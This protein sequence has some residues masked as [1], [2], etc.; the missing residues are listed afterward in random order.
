VPSPPPSISISR[1]AARFALPLASWWAIAAFARR[2][3]IASGAAEGAYL[4]LLAAAVLL[5]VSEIAPWPA[6]ELGI[7][8]LLAAAVVWALP[9]GPAR[10]TVFLVVLTAAFL[11]AACRRL[12]GA[13]AREGLPFGAYAALALGSQF[14][15]R[16]HLLFAPERTLKT[17]V[18]LLVLPL[19]GAA[20]VA[21]TARREGLGPT[22]TAAALSLLLAPGWNVSSTL[23]WVALAATVSLARRE[24]DGKERLAAF[25]VLLAVVLKAPAP[26]LVAALCGLALV[27]PLVAL[28]LAAAAFLGLFPGMGL[29]RSFHGAFETAT[30]ALWAVLAVPAILW[31]ERERWGRAAVALLLAA[32]VVPI[33]NLGV[34]AAPFALAGLAAGR[35][36]AVAIP[37]RL[38]AGV[39]LG[40]CA[41]LASY[42]WLRPT[43]LPVALGLVGLAPGW[44]PLLALAGVLAALA[45]LYRSFFSREGRVARDARDAREGRPA[46]AD[47]HGAM[48]AAVAV[49]VAAALH[50]QPTGRPLLTPEIPVL[51]DASRPVWQATP[52]D[53]RAASHIAVE[54]S[55]ANAATLS[56]GTPVAKVEWLGAGGRREEWT[57]RAGLDTGEWAAQRPDVRESGR[58][59]ARGAWVSWVSDGF[60][61]QRYRCR[62]STARPFRPLLIRIERDP[63]LPVEVSLA[64]HQVE[65]GP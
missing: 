8:A 5:A 28:P 16:G 42:P 33:P 21:L 50:L 27:R 29:L 37:Q 4:A 59:V 38:W 25:A 10:G 1:T 36:P 52:D 55:L 45:L 39:L 15:L 30:Q 44:L 12:L 47:F 14:L 34:L 31:P 13:E 40:A 19:L 20:A 9:P 23:G 64:I 49:F 32:A 54:S 7:G 3:A 43:P 41:L 53:S 65:A 17:L 22:V 46:A 57:L 11:T 60:F 6:P 18:A 58:P 63:R 2:D 24:S 51:L 35:R 48:L 26:G 61:A 56:A 62:Y